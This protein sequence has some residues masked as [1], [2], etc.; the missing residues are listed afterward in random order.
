MPGKL[1]ESHWLSNPDVTVAEQGLAGEDMVDTAGRTACRAGDEV[2]Q[3][4]MQG[5]LAPWFCLGSRGS[6][7]EFG[8]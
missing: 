7:A 1:P 2:Q 5:A 6:A 4:G 8:V 3:G